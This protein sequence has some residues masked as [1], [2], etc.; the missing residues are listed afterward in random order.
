M[1]HSA[2]WNK[3]FIV[4]LA[5]LQFHT[6]S[7]WLDCNKVIYFD[8]EATLLS[9]KND[10]SVCDIKNTSKR[11]ILHIIDDIRGSTAKV[12]PNIFEKNALVTGAVGVADIAFPN[13]FLFIDRFIDVVASFTTFQEDFVCVQYRKP[14]AHYF[15]DGCTW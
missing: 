14:P 3:D 13:G 11:F 10:A 6:V 8:I 5:A 2:I 9:L 12:M 1:C 4:S 7:I 15:L